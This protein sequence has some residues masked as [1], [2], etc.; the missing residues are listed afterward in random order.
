[1]DLRN[2]TYGQ[3][4]LAEEFFQLK[5]SIYGLTGLLF[6]R[7]YMKIARIPAIFLLC[8]LLS[9]ETINLVIAILLIVIFFISMLYRNFYLIEGPFFFICIV[10]VS[11]PMLTE[12]VSHLAILKI[13]NSVVSS[14]FLLLRSTFYPRLLKIKNE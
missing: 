5:C 13:W 10:L 12:Y 11:S 3:M 14:S 6:Y 8:V 4:H 1:M 9:G 2:R 7:H